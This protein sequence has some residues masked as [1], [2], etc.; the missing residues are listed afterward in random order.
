MLEIT[1]TRTFIE[2][3][4][5]NHFR[6]LTFSAQAEYVTKMKTNEKSQGAASERSISQ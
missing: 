4:T 6:S 5:E 2:S 3:L 1:V